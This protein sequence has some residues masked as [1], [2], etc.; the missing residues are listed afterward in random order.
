MNYDQYLAEIFSEAAKCWKLEELYA[1]IDNHK[2]KVQKKPLNSLE[3]AI[4]RGIL[5]GNST[6]KIANFLPEEPYG[7]IINSTWQLYRY[8][9]TLTANQNQDVDNYQNIPH[10]LETAGYKK[11]SLP[12]PLEESTEQ[13]LH[14]GKQSLTTITISPTPVVSTHPVSRQVLPEDSDRNSHSNTA[15]ILR[16]EKIEIG[17]EETRSRS[18]E[19]ALTVQN[20]VL[21]E[22]NTLTFV[23]A[24]DFMPPIS[25]WTKL[26][27]LFMAGSVGVA[28]AL[29]AF[30]PYNVTVQAQAKVRPAGELRI[31]E[32]ETEGTVVEIAAK[33]NQKLKKGDLIAIIDNS[34]L[35]TQKSQLESNIQQATLQLKQIQ[36]QITAHNY[37]LIAETDRSD[38]IIASAKAE[39]N[40]RRREYQDRQITTTTEVEEAEANLK[41]AEAALNSARSRLKRYQA[42]AT[43]GALSKDQL[44]EVQ[45][46]VKEQEQSVEANQA[47]LKRA[48]T[49][50]NPID[51]EIAIALENIAQ[52]QASG[53]ATLAT[54][55]QEKEALIQQQIEIQ[56]QQSRDRQELQQIEKDLKQTAIKATVDG[57]LFQLNLRN[58]GQT[59]TLGEEIAQIAPLSNSLVI[60]ALV[61]AQEIDTV[62][63]E[64]QVQMKVSAC[65]YPDYG[66]LKGT[67]SNIAP[68]S[69][70][71]QNSD[72]G[73][74]NSKT[75]AQN[76][77]AGFYQITIKPESLALGK[78]KKQ[79][80]IQAGME[81]KADIIAQEETVLKFLLRKAR[82]L[83]DL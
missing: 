16:D 52:E 11:L 31:V 34:R 26:G 83:T 59:V 48:Q 20:S 12:Q 28:I 55:K 33:G 46:A 77:E 7:F 29:S 44:D 13:L 71:P 22:T 4:L 23:E 74:N 36:A 47:R 81:G 78:G 3:Q 43:E 79:C 56:Q 8:I 58:S 73:S 21:S 27:G 15:L 5:S 62:E 37:R 6:E 64:Q 68:D 72:S 82:L 9:Q 18:E 1:A 51:A 67:V 49:A 50:L 30:T 66:T 17:R 53:Q 54:L 25:L 75:S 2:Q 35:K 38:R 57:I 39:L 19:S 42:A 10:L 41:A 76:L 70:T 32:A 61:P 63:I 14:G 60:K 45:V 24:N 40:R 69:I 65:P 80:K